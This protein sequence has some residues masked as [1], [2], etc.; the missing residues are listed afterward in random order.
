MRHRWFWGTGC[1]PSRCDARHSAAGTLSRHRGTPLR[2]HKDFRTFADSDPDGPDSFENCGLV[3]RRLQRRA[4]WLEAESSESLNRALKPKIRE[5][6]DF[7]QNPPAP[8]L[9]R[10]RCWVPAAPSLGALLALLGAPYR[11]VFSDTVSF[12]T[13]LPKRWQQETHRDSGHS[14]APLPVVFANFAYEAG[15]V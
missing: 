11:S 4:R 3:S 13:L 2:R 1:G 6:D 15:P 8:A 12:P 14:G 10:Y 9:R 7:I 5:R